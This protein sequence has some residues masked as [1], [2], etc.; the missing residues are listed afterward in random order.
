MSPSSR[1]SCRAA[2][3]VVPATRAYN[4]FRFPN[5][6]Y[7]LRI[8][9]GSDGTDANI[10]FTLQGTLGTST[11]TVDTSHVGRMESGDTNYVT[12]PSQDLGALQSITVSNDGTGNGPDW[13]LL[14]IAVSSARYMGAHSCARGSDRGVSI[15]S[16]PLTGRAR[17]SS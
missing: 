17:L 6:A 3:D 8:R 14:D 15:R 12:I 7:A 2:R 4:P 1:A 10:T 9:T 13:E 16:S 5:E 11:I